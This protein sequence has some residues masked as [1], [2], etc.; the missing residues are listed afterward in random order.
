VILFLKRNI[1]I[2]NI[3]TIR[4]LDFLNLFCRICAEIPDI[5]ERRFFQSLFRGNFSMVFG[6]FAKKFLKKGVF[7]FASFL[8]DEQKK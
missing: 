1:S 5:Q 6:F 8:L 7:F 2:N 4:K 3:T